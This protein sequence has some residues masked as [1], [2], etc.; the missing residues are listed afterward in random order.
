MVLLM[1]LFV[2]MNLPPWDHARKSEHEAKSIQSKVEPGSV[3]QLLCG[4]QGFSFRGVK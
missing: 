4:L 2:T 3:Q 1:L